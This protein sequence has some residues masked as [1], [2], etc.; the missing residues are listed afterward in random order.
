MKGHVRPHGLAE[1]CVGSIILLVLLSVAAGVFVKQFH[2]DR[3]MFV[4]LTPSTSVVKSSAP[5]P[6][7]PTETTTTAFIDLPGAL[8]PLSAPE[9]FTPDNLYDKI[10]G[11]AELYTSAGVV[12]MR[13]QRLALK[14]DP[15]AWMEFF[16]YDMD[17]L[18][19]S[20]AVYS[21]QQRADAQPLDF[22]TYAYKTKNALFFCCGRYY[23]EAVT[24]A[25]TEAMMAAMVSVS[26]LFVAKHP[27]QEIR[28]A[29]LDFF[30]REHQA[31]N[32]YM[33]QP[34]NAFGFD[35]FKNVFSAKYT[36]NG[37]DVMAFLTIQ[38]SA[39]DAAALSAAYQQFVLTNGGHELAGSG[40]VPTAKLAEMMGSVELVFARGK[41]VG[42]V[43]AAPNAEAAEQ[44][45][46]LLDAKI[47]KA[48]K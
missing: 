44:A 26:K 5:A 36:I 29:E 35:K 18:R 31:P 14:N 28:V 37:A 10:D 23:I 1:T 11:K 47:S 6:S 3:A 43:H 46:A 42:G 41:V 32:S 15:N 19:Q 21:M 27:P 24:A 40:K 16:V 7:A 8:K 34:E 12:G 9:T 33:F 48:T 30:P 45:A 4:A 39:G 25:P 2:Y 17:N 20:F 13:C 22:A 38:P